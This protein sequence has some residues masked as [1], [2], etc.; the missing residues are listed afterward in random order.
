MIRSNRNLFRKKIL[1][2][3]YRRVLSFPVFYLQL[4]QDWHVTKTQFKVE[5]PC[6]NDNLKEFSLD[7]AVSNWRCY[8]VKPS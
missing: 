7:D 3:V 5:E 6:A 8:T 4:K 2:H 1:V